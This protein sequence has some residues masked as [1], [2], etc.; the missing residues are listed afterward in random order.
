MTVTLS[1]REITLLVN[2]SRDAGLQLQATAEENRKID[3]GL[4]ADISLELA[5]EYFQIGKKLSQ[6]PQDTDS[7][8]PS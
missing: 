5:A 3:N 1:E 2:A 4:A 6:I 8:N 7:T